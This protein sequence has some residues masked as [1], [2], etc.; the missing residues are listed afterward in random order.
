MGGC[1]SLGGSMFRRHGR[2]VA[3]RAGRTETVRGVG[4]EGPNPST[5]GGHGVEACVVA[6][7]VQSECGRDMYSII[8]Q[9]R[10]LA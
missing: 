8:G 1:G 2:V 10:Y 6:C 3:R 7:A 4:V 9:W 5:R